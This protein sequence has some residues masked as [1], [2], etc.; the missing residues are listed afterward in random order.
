M[1]TAIQEVYSGDGVVVLMD[2]GSAVLSAEMALDMLPPERRSLASLYETPLVEGA[3]AATVQ[4]RLGRPLAQV[5]AEA[6]GALA[7]K[8]SHLGKTTVA[9]RKQGSRRKTSEAK[10]IRMCFA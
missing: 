1:L 6:L 2:L 9:R 8:A 5:I 10:V 7:A 4:A 3:I